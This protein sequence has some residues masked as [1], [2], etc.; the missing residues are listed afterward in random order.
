M[1]T[2]LKFALIIHDSSAHALEPQG[3]GALPSTSPH[4]QPT[5]PSIDLLNAYTV[6]RKNVPPKCV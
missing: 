4:V 1:R 5:K 6:V 2:T 3:R